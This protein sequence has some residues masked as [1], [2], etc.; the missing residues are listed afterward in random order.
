MS[1][2]H[3]YEHSFQFEAG[4]IE[5]VNKESKTITLKYNYH[6]DDTFKVINGYLVAEEDAN[7]WKGTWVQDIINQYNNL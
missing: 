3:D 1:K 4:L 7:F 6:L 2:Y 5:S